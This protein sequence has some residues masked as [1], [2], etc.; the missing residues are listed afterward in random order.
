MRASADT[1]IVVC[2]LDPYG[3]Q[4]GTV[5]FDMARL[6]LDWDAGFTALD[7]ITGSTWMWGAHTYVRLDPNQAC[8]HV[9]S[10]RRGMV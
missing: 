5:H 7:E 1:V 6:G 10:V 2:T 8:A 4:E 3:A 9:V